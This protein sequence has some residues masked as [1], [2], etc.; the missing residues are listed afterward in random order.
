VRGVSLVTVEIFVQS[1]AANNARYHSINQKNKN[2]PATS[3]FNIVV[4]IYLK[5][6][7]LKLIFYTI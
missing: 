1:R 3:D 2:I 7:V 6:K 5:L 4:F